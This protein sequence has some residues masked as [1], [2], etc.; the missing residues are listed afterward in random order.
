[1]KVLATND[2][3]I[4][5]PGLWAVVEAL[6]DMAEVV[7]VASDRDQSGVG[8]S[9]TLRAPVRVTKVAPA[10]DGVT[11]YSV[12][13]TPADSV[14]VA[15]EKL[16]GTVDLVVAGINMGANLGSDVVLSGTVGAA[17][18]GY[19][20]DI[21]SVA[22]SV[23]SLHATRFEAATRLL[24][25]V[26]QQ[27]A[28]DS[29]PRP[30]LLNINMPPLPPEEIEGIEVTRLAHRTYIEN[31]REGDDGKRPYYWITRSKAEW[32]LEEGADVWAIHHKRVSITPL[33]TDITASGTLEALKDLPPQ[34]LSA[35]Q[36]GQAG[37][38]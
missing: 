32:E 3:G 38:S 28:E 9:L 19:N 30:L 18:Q 31:I 34:L 23:T 33:H 13:G 14:I 5:S 2:D 4:N 36:A 16:V 22:I 7:V 15:L 10:V 21:P 8:P 17:L 35:L 12:E 27:V 25:V 26:A 24:K 29:L 37:G 20:R 11:T 1:M 6:G